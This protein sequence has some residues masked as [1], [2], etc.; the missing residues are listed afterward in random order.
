MSS[1]R[2]IAITGNQ[3]L[4]IMQFALVIGAWGVRR[5]ILQQFLRELLDI[6]LTCFEI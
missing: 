1:S 2:K 5:L 6:L 4:L 3:V